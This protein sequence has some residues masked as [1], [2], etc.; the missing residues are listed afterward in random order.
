MNIYVV[1][2]KSDKSIT[3]FVFDDGSHNVFTE[4]DDHALSI[5][6]IDWT[7]E[8]TVGSDTLIKTFE[9]VEDTVG[10]F[11]SVSSNGTLTKIT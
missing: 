5:N 3:Q 4:E 1:Y 10:T 11:L 6:T 8:K 2:K 9:D 7:Q